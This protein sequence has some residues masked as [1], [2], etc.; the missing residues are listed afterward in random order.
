MGFKSHS[1]ENIFDN[2]LLL[3]QYPLLNN[4][5][6]SL[7]EY[8][9]KENLK[10]NSELRIKLKVIKPKHNSLWFMSWSDIIELRLAIS[11]N[12]MFECFR[13]VYGINE[14]QFSK[15][16]LLNAFASYKWMAENFKAI[17][18]VEVEQ[19]ASE[20]TEEEKE[21]GAED[22]QQFTYSVAL[23]GLTKGDLLKYDAYL[24]LPYT[25]IFRKLCLDKTRYDINK[26]LQENASRKSQRNS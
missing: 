26:Q 9:I 14:K 10:V 5:V 1:I 3:A 22:L 25:K 13:I 19:L 24:Q 11:E 12:N 8:T 6:K 2:R 16:E 17:I 7:I 20:L 15:L 21:A 18:D 23:D 4:E